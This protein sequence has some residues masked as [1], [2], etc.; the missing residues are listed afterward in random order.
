MQVLRRARSAKG[1]LVLWHVP[2]DTYEAFEAAI[3][4][5]KIANLSIV[6]D[7]VSEVIERKDERERGSTVKG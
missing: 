6:R 5:Q 7:E 1:A 4:A 2:K 3:D